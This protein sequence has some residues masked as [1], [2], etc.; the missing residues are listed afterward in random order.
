[1][2][3]A[4]LSDIHGNSVAL[5]AVLADVRQCGR[6]DAFWILGDLV[7]LGPDPV[8]VLDRLC[9]LENARFIRGN[10]D[11]YVAMGDRPPPSI[12]DVKA[13]LS[14]LPR[15][16]EVAQTFTWTQGMVTSAGKLSWL[17]QLPLELRATLPDG[18]R[19]LGVH[20]SPGRDDGDGIPPTLDDDAIDQLLQTAEADILCCGHT[21]RPLYRRL[22]RRSMVNPGSVSLSSTADKRSSYVVLEAAATGYTIDERKVPYDIQRV[23][24]ML[25]S[26]E[27]PGRSFIIRHLTSTGG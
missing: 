15:S 9:A 5:D 4:I 22:G 26:M 3:V 13:D 18:T 23:V 20:A 7:A 19:F 8:G 6:I 11:R 2:R 27:H 17:Q 1:M 25:V 21:H 10:T 14:L 12:E 24:Q 16:I